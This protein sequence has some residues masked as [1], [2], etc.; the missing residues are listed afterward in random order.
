[1]IKK[2]RA[3]DKYLKKFIQSEY[4][5][6]GLDGTLIQ[7]NICYSNDPDDTWDE[8]WNEELDDDKYIIEQFT[9]LSDRNGREIYEGDI[10]KIGEE[11]SSHIPMEKDAIE[12][13]SNPTDAKSGWYWRGLMGQILFDSGCFMTYQTNNSKIRFFPSYHRQYK[14]TGNVHENNA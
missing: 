4:F 1:M 10:V 7:R 3:W 2:F 8:S 13:W 14:I 5:A 12:L 11:W 6:I 9:G